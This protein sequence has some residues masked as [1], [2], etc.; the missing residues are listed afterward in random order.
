VAKGQISALWASH[1]QKCATA[2][3]PPA[4]DSYVFGT[5]RSQRAR[6]PFPI[7]SGDRGDERLKGGPVTLQPLLDR[8]EAV[9]WPELDA[10]LTEQDQADASTQT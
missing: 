10:K 5:P 9:S 3:F 2:L 1:A 7:T 4:S 8:V 6:S